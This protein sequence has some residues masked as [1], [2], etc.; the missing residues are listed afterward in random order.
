[1][2]RTVTRATLHQAAARS[3]D[4]AY[5]LKQ[6]VQARLAAVEVLRQDYLRMLPDAAGC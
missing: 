2:N 5:W 1:M 6:P 3:E 4:L